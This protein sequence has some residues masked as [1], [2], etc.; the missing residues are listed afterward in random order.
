[1]GWREAQLVDQ[2]MHR[3]VD[4]LM[5]PLMAGSWTSSWIADRTMPAPARL[6]NWPRGE[7]SCT[8]Y[9]VM[10][11]PSFTSTIDRTRP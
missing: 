6:G 3:L 7:W 11:L 2:V 5:G 4:Q 9:V 1:M 10:S 8:H